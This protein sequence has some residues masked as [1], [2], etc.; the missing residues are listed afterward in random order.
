[1]GGV[2]EHFCSL[3]PCIPRRK[4]GRRA[5]PSPAP[6]SPA[7]ADAGFVRRCGRSRTTRL[8]TSGASVRLPP[9]PPTHASAHTPLGTKALRGP[10]PRAPGGEVGWGGGCPTP[11]EDAVLRPDSIP[12][13]CARRHPGD[14][15]RG[16]RAPALC[17]KRVRPPSPREAAPAQRE[18]PHFA[19]NVCAPPPPSLPYSLDTPRPSPRTNWT[20][21]ARPHPMS[22]N[23]SGPGSPR[24][25]QKTCAPAEPPG[26]G[27]SPARFL[28]DLTESLVLFKTLLL[29]VSR[30]PLMCRVTRPPPPC[31]PY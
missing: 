14:R 12:A 5:W 18:P 9:P 19:E 13:N 29:S 2:E 20:R 6:P 21:T 24:T 11:H 1:V 3:T 4:W 16:A 10:A 25:L 31:P 23:R 22:E 17:R 26:G 8:S 7:G 27:A 28:R 15:G 30:A